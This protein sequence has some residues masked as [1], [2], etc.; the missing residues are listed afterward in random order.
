MGSHNEP[1]KSL[2]RHSEHHLLKDR[3]VWRRP[4]ESPAAAA[5]L[6]VTLMSPSAFAL[7]GA[8]DAVRVHIAS[9]QRRKMVH[10][11]S[12]SCPVYRG[13]IR[14]PCGAVWQD[15][16]PQSPASPRIMLQSAKLGTITSRSP[17]HLPTPVSLTHTH[18]DERD[19]RAEEGLSLINRIKWTIT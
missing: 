16:A 13:S 17:S 14:S 2:K 19:R 3:E 6:P 8:A 1:E 12:L 9:R 4:Q 11:L 7:S 15:A 18:T 10:L 5:A